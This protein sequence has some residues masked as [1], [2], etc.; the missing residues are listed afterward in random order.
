MATTKSVSF[1]APYSSKTFNTSQNYLVGANGVLQGGVVSTSGTTVSVTPLTFIQQGIIVNTDYIATA[2]LPPSIT[3]PYY[4]VVST[5]GPIEDISEVITPTFAKRPEDISANSVLV[6][7]YDGQEWRQLPYVDINGVVQDKNIRAVVDGLV[8]VASGFDVSADSG[9]IYVTPGAAHAA[10]GSLVIK[11]ISTTLPK[12][13]ADPDGFDR[14]DEIVLRK[15][16]D[17]PSRIATLQYVVGPT[18]NAGGTTQLLTPHQLS[19]VGN[20]AAKTLSNPTS[21]QLYFFYM[22]TGGALKFR[23]ATNNFSSL[24]SAISLA[25]SVTSFDVL[26]D[27]VGNLDLVY[28]KGTSIY[29]QSISGTGT[30][31]VAETQIY[32]NSN[33][34]SGVRALPVLASGTQFIH[35][36][37]QQY[38]SPSQNQIFYTRILASGASMT[39]AQVLVDLSAAL[40]NPSLAKDDDD[41]TLFLAFEN[42]S[43]AAV[44][45]RVYDT[46]T[47]TSSAAPSQIGTPLQL[48]DNTYDLSTATLLAST[49]AT[50]PIVRHTANKETYVFWRHSKGSGNYGV[51]VYNANYQNTF[52]YKAVVKDL[53]AT[54]ENVDQYGVSIDGLNVAHVI[55]REQGT[56]GAANLRLS[57]FVVSEVKQILASAGTDCNTHITPRGA[58][59]HTYANGSNAFAVKSTAGLITS[60]RDR[61][62]PPTDVYIAHYRN[63]DGQL[64]V[65]GTALEEDRSI[66]RLYEYGTMFAA[67][68][69]VTWGGSA[70][71]LLT[72]NAPLTMNFFNRLGT[73]TIP[74]NSPSGVTVANGTVCYV[75]VPDTDESVSLTLEFA[76]FGSGTLDRYN[77]NVIPLFWAEGGVVYTKFAP[78]L[79]DSSG[80]TVIIGEPLTQNAQ[81]W[82]GL[83]SLNPDPTNHNYSSAT[84]IAQGDDYNTA[85]GKLD[86]KVAGILNSTITDVVTI[87][88]GATSL[89][90]TW[91]STLPANTFT[92]NATMENQTDS[93]PQFQNV[94]VTAKSTTTFTVSWNAPTDSG[95]YFIDFIL[96]QSTE[97]AGIQTLTNGSVGQTVTF[98]APL[99]VSN[100]RVVVT[101]ENQVDGSPQFQ[102]LNI[103]NKTVNGFTVNWNAPLDSSNYALDW[104][105]YE[106]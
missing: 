65:S 38:V 31:V 98:G 91:G 69:V 44:F 56:I 105:L 90:V 99:G 23:Y 50:N 6:A 29:Y 85:L 76:D 103:S 34:V 9:N 20:F 77:R 12:V 25:T 37:W 5:V 61:Y 51:A 40:A 14:I 67:T 48:Q 8:G 52:G 95:N 81:T 27:A 18:F 92:L 49:G 42:Q 41:S 79:I 24:S 3:A 46:S 55:V 32:T 45:L 54:N 86:A 70:T 78:F 74:S 13:T 16:A 82:L 88:N 66:K 64:S 35:I 94:V 15:P 100:F 106:S 97:Y 84:T 72:L 22:E 71:N 63:S 73:Y 28:I 17:D 26:Q 36:V 33:A 68:G 2:T 4:L 59:I 93:D 62:L 87:P 104:I 1:A 11:N 101:M 80:G 30:S 10:D 21:D 58:L 75:Q 57:D 39:T 7:A 83:P 60:L 43:T 96:T 47:A 19:S 53:Y 102:P 89:T